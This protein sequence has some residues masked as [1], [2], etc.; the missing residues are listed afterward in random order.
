MS[1]LPPGWTWATLEE[2]LAVEDRA[3][4]DGPFGSKLASRHYTTSGARVIRLQNIGDCI[5]ND[6]HAYIS[7][8]YFEELR[9]HE[10]CAGDLVAA[11][12]G[13]ELPRA[14]LIPELGE[15]AIVKADCIRARIHPEV[16]TKWVL[17]ALAAPQTRQYAASRI[18]G[19]GR[20]RLGL[21]EMRRLPIPLPPLTEQRLIVSALDDHLSQLDSGA[22]QLKRVLWRVNSFRDQV[23]AAACTGAFI[24]PMDS[25]A[26]KPSPAG[27]SDGT[28]PRIPS[29]W[30]WMRLGEIAEVVGGVTKDTKKQSDPG[31]PEVPYLRVANVQRGRLDLSEVAKIRVS[32]ETAKKLELYP[33]DVLLNE[34]GDRDK[35]GRG[36]IWEGQITQC[37]HQNHVFRARIFDDILKP[38]LLAWH[39]NGFGRRWCE[40]NGKQSV[41]LASISLS[42]IKLLPV[43]VPPRDQQD[44]LVAEAER[45]L[46]LLDRAERAALDALGRT[47]RLRRS[48]LA[49][50][51]A[52]RLV[53]QDP[54][55]EPSSVL[56]ERISAQRAAEPRT[57]RGRSI[58]KPALQEETLL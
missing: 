33:G 26:K 20:P 35:L 45:H 50:A 40:A 44:T 9:A 25:V 11:S 21:G 32:R 23:I 15:P 24:E 55:D 14:C 22:S 18:R 42:K 29:S 1:N 12:L 6:E 49:E 52:G 7:L 8:D 34:G 30:N 46:T 3:I 56:L 39:A 5:F 31:T 17:Y 28:L 19:V 10:A 57:R 16:D 37:I 58:V 27:I 41:N 13:D 36:W 38:R 48:L 4:T 47:R 54:K 51:F 53:L 2:L 43:P